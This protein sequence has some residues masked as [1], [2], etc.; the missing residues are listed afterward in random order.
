[1]IRNFGVGIIDTGN[2]LTSHPMERERE[3]E[4]ERYALTK[5][6]I[7]NSASASGMIFPRSIMMSE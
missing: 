5:I 1:M 7:A 2:H 3:R 6:N 4:R